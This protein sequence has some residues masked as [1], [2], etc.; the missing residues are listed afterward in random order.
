LLFA[1]GVMAWNLWGAGPSPLHDP[2]ARPRSVAPR[3]DLLPEEYANVELFQAASPSVVFVT[4]IASVQ[5]QSWFRP[6]VAEVKQGEGSGFIW[7]TDGH[8][9]TNHHVVSGGDR[10]IVTLADQTS[11]EARKVGV[12]QYHDLAVL[13]IDVPSKQL[14]ALPLGQS[15]GLLVGQKVFAIGNPFG[16]NHTLTTGI[17]SGLGREIKAYQTEAPIS[18]VIQTD[19]AINPGNSG[20]PLLDSSGRLIGVNTAIAS[21]LRISAG[22][23][24]AVPVDV[25]NRAIPEIIRYGQ[26]RRAGLGVYLVRDDQAERAGIEGV[27]IREVQEGSA[28]EAAGLRSALVTTDGQV[29]ADIIVGV[30]SLAVRR[31]EDL[32]R[33]L[34]KHKVGD[35]VQVTVQRGDQERTVA[36]R[37]Q[38]L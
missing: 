36:I 21:P 29:I 23:G 6:D 38:D 20:G 32:Y 7:D 19:A 31:F 10:F 15:E 34:S 30:N 37:L 9:V 18:G 35:T 5:S 4:N 24:F 26:P 3:G 8:I 28:A 25:V 12:D 22:V 1:I 14:K 17:I 11:W 2:D 33:E 16:L 27:V 13:K